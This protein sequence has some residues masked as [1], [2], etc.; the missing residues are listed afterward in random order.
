M[1]YPD[2]EKYSSQFD[3]DD[4]QLCEMLE[5]STAKDFLLCNPTR[6]LAN[7]NYDGKITNPFFHDYFHVANLLTYGGLLKIY[8]LSNNNHKNT[9]FITGYR[10]S[11]KTTFSNYLAEIINDKWF[12]DTIRR[13]DFNSYYKKKG[14]RDK[15]STYSKMYSE[16]FDRLLEG[17]LESVGKNRN[18]KR[19][20]YINIDMLS[21]D[22]LYQNINE[23]IENLNIGLKGNCYRFNLETDIDISKEKPIS[24][25]L[26][27]ILATIL[28]RWFS[29]IDKE[30][31]NEM[32][33]LVVS[34]HEFFRNHFDA[35]ALALFRKLF[36]FIME[37]IVKYSGIKYIP[38]SVL[39]EHL[40]SYNLDELLCS[41][42][43]LD[44]F[45]MKI[46]K[47]P[48]RKLFYL[49]DNLDII[50][51]HSIEYKFL[52][53]YN[54]FVTNFAEVVKKLQKFQSTDTDIR[55]DFN[56]SRDYCCIFFMRDTTAKYTIQHY[57]GNMNLYSIN[58]DSSEFVD[59]G[60][61]ILRRMEYVSK[62]DV[63][64]RINPRLFEQIDMLSQIFQDD[65]I[66]L[67]I[68]GLFNNDYVRFVTCLTEI[69]ESNFDILKEY[70]K[71]K[72]N[73]PHDSFGNEE[74]VR[75]GARGLIFR[76][77][78]DHFEDRGYLSRLGISDSMNANGYTQ[79]RLVLFYLFNKQPV[80]CSSFFNSTNAT[81]TF[82]DLKRDFLDVF[83]D[84]NES[85]T[86]KVE[87]DSLN[88]LADALWNMY[89]L[90]KSPTWAHLV[91][92][93]AIYPTNNRD[94]LDDD[95]SRDDI[96]NALIE[97]STGHIT[98]TCAG[99]SYVEFMCSHFEFFSMRFGS[100]T[101]GQRRYLHR[102]P[103]FRYEHALF[104]SA[105][106]DYS[107]FRR[108]G[109]YLFEVLL[110]S[111]FDDFSHHLKTHKQS[112][113]NMFKRKGYYGKYEILGSPYVFHHPRD[114]YQRRHLERTLH[115]MITYMDAY[116]LFLVNNIA[117]S[118]ETQVENYNTRMIACIEPFVNLVGDNRASFSAFS[119]H[120]YTR[121]DWNMKT[122]KADLKDK[123]TGLDDREDNKD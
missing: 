9:V 108:T 111:M 65:Y 22:E 100:I 106:Y 64:E 4:D 49:F 91:T 53:E 8:G 89:D 28:N 55:F 84:K 116:R 61:I 96:M 27:H 120:A 19:E 62:H 121:Y 26:R 31:N 73:E 46:N 80:H 99:R 115:R 15:A 114:G 110:E 6:S 44:I 54:L 70:L 17:L 45:Q 97:G 72:N 40:E 3:L 86:R 52:D 57:F 78:F 21:R 48:K 35:G 18:A 71:I 42:M 90:K 29:S 12:V 13:T 88:I 14:E 113:E 2:R 41:V 123:I 69:C 112:E 43:L 79:A 34:V 77:I 93:D 68:A 102:H 7:Q 67:N 98:I 83:N 38:G 105:T 109:K 81:V 104:S 118:N 16:R 25:K 10:G 117:K 85:S 20:D 36:D 60:K 37:D 5:H 76:V 33:T 24:Q 82:S 50:E 74:L 95:L 23:C 92:F 32:L 87:K 119:S 30:Q 101:T 122:I 59:K 39:A 58:F 47:E 1:L 103:E 56:F 66:R 107:Y 75:Y 94:K 11:G 51:N 63:I